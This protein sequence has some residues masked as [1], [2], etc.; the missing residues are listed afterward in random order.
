MIV[1]VNRK[2]LSQIRNRRLAAYA[3]MYVT[4]YENFMRQVEQ[5]GLEFEP[6]SDRPQVQALME[7]IRRKGGGFRNDDKSVYL[8]EISPACVACQTGVG[9][10]TFFVSLRCHRDCFYCFNPNQQDFEFFQSHQRSVTEELKQV[11]AAGQKIAHLALTGGE[12]LLHKQEAAD[13][14]GYASENFPDTYTRLYTT[15]DQADAAT[16]KQLADAGLDEIRL[17]IRMHDLARGHRHTFERVALAQQYIP[18]VMIE[19]PVLP[20]T[21]E[22]MKDVLLE[23][24]RLKLYSI[25]LL[26]FC[27]P[28]GN[29]DAFRTRGYRLK[30][31]PYRVLYDYW[32]AGGL[33]V[34]GSELECLQLVDFALD[35]QMRMGVHYCSL[36]NKHTGQVYQQNFNQP[37]PKTACFSE[38]D[39]FLKTAKAFGA[40]VPKV[41]KQLQRSG[42]T[43]YTIDSQYDYIEFHVDQM[44]ALRTLDVEIGLCSGIL[45]TRA[46]G[47]YLRELQVDLTSPR[48]FDRAH[49]V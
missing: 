47:Q 36:E 12:P 30:R 35:Q 10:A 8:N 46:D 9:S 21:L 43:D 26:E 44:A 20:G 25:N 1:A 34:A 2:T 15:G 11:H 28:L 39:Y 37:K 41:V 16:L 14:F 32:Y 13:F 49:D 6:E 45:E 38:R 18:R 22:T 31:Q 24:E 40:D 48:S 42:C 27:F 33:P 5:I 3:E 23:L 4:I 29:A 19:M 17:S 7:Q